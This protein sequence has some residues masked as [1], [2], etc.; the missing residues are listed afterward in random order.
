[1]PNSPKCCSDT[2]D[3]ADADRGFL[4]ALQP[5]VVRAADGRVVWESDSYA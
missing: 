2:T 5:G 3:F 1:M 4:G